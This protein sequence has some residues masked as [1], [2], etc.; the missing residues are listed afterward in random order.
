MFL[1]RY[2]GAENEKGKRGKRG[3]EEGR[4]DTT[5][6]NLLFSLSSSSLFLSLFPSL[7]QITRDCSS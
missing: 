5:I 1:Q 2:G 3:E 7:P 4:R 6:T